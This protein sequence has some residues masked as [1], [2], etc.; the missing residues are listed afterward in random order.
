MKR[1]LPATTSAP[2]V[3]RARKYT[4]V[5]KYTEV[6]FQLHS[7]F[8]YMHPHLIP[9]A[10]GPSLPLRFPFPRHIAS[11]RLLQ[12]STSCKCCTAPPKRRAVTLPQGSCC[13]AG[14]Q[15]VVVLLHE[16]CDALCC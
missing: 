9:A 15:R 13:C 12:M 11:L 5:Q 7:L 2:P 10:P 14:L 4:K 6:Q 16:V 3:P 8:L 1:Q